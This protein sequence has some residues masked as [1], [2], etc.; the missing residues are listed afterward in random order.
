LTAATIFVFRKRIKE[1]A[2]Y[3]TI[4]YPFTPLIFMAMSAFIVVNT[5]IEKPVQAV[6][7]LV[8]LGIGVGVFYA[9]KHNKKHNIV[10]NQ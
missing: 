8:F 10:E 5:L 1:A 6:A 9:F 2:T 3:R 7:G 4:G